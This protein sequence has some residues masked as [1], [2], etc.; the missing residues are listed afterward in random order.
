MPRKLKLF[1]RFN[2]NPNVQQPVQALLGNIKNISLLPP[3]DYLPMAHLMKAATLILTDSG[4][5]QEEAA[6][7]HK[8]ALVLREVTERPE[9]VQAGVLKLVGTNP[10]K[11]ISTTRLLLENPAVYQRMASAAN[12]FGDGYAAEKIIEALLNF[13]LD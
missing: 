6:A 11:I 4:G 7:L 13:Q 8:P 5:L 1:T 10:E 9:G 3:L 12:P 2:L